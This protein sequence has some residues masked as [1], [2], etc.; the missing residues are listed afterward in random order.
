VDTLFLIRPRIQIACNSRYYE[1]ARRVHRITHVMQ[2]N[3]APTNDT[4]RSASQPPFLSEGMS[5]RVTGSTEDLYCRRVGPISSATGTPQYPSAR[6]D[7]GAWIHRA[8]SDR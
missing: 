8:R 4:S 5:D 2:I 3:A 7:V 1:W 6:E